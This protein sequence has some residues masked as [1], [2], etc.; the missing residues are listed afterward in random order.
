MG[1]QTIQNSLTD[2]PGI[3]V[4]HCT[5]PDLLSGVT[6]VLTQRETVGGVDVR[7]GAPGTR[8]TDLLNPV[9]LVETIHGVVI[10]GN[11]VFGLGAAGGVVRFLEERGIGFPVG[12]GRVVPIVPAAVLFDLGRGRRDGHLTEES[13]YTACQNAASGPIEQGNVG[14]GTGAVAGE[15]KGGIGTASELLEGGIIV[16][17]LVAVNSFGSPV[18]PGTGLFYARHLE[19]AG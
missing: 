16:G 4:G 19:R 17:G 10:C 15:L 11:S 13:G 5:D 8:E 14:A 2:V 7:G 18:D 9:N 3:S 6:V 12:S 1:G